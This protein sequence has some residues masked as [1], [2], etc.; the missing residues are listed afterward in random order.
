MKALKIFTVLFYILGIQLIFSQ[1]PSTISYQGILTDA[2]G[3]VVSDGSYTLTFG[4]YE[5]PTGGTPFWQEQHTV[6]VINGLFN[7]ILGSDAPLDPPFQSQYWLGIKIGSDPELM[8]RIQLTASP[9][10][11]N[12]RSVVGGT[13]VFPSEGNVGI[14][15]PEPQQKLHVAGISRFDVSSNAHVDISTPGGWP[16]LITIAPGGNRR[17]LIFDDGGIRLLTSPSSSA[18]PAQNGITIRENGAVGIGINV[19]D[20]QLSVAGTVE[21]T[22]GGFK[23]PDGSVQTSAAT[24]G[25][26]AN[27][28]KKNSADTSQ[29][30]DISPILL[31]SNLG[32]GDGFNG[33]SVD[34]RGVEGRSENNNGVQ[35]WTGSATKSAVFGNSI[36]GRGVEGRSETQ[37]GVDG[38]TGVSEASGV[39]GHS[40]DGFGVTGRSDNNR[41]IQ[42][43]GPT[44]IYGESSADYGE[45]IHG[46]GTGS[47]TEG[48]L[49]T[50]DNNVGV[51]G[52]S[53]GTTGNNFGVWGASDD[54]IGVLGAS[55]SGTALYAIGTFA[56]TG[57][58]SA[59]VKLKDGTPIRL[60]SEEATEVNF[61]DYGSDQLVNG[62]RHI[63]LDPVFLQTV[64]VNSANPMRV[65]VQLEGDC[66]GVYVTNKS[67][68]GFDVVELGGGNSSVPFSYRVVCKRKYFESQRLATP[69]ENNQQNKVM[70]QTVWPE[71]LEKQKERQERIFSKTGVR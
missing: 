19:P 32:S 16:G 52:I 26:A 43:F 7:I 21:S 40:T 30:T 42:G 45:A 10:S 67:N 70:M 44:A 18:A 48:V 64:T 66:N 37:D 5:A 24:G 39:F 20:E 61:C 60:F 11:L 13:N 2:G 63:E 25:G 55:T 34:G 56:A 31:V 12:A 41:G 69:E 38:W 46:H 33:R 51:Y 27:Y 8:P 59:E 62:R 68:T 50:S 49:G 4:L 29:A 54:G 17:D 36:N 6:D 3:T 58:K 47:F 14:G 22:T 1:V 28:I 15:V 57:T 9:Y 71:V 53:S 23:F 65:F 35:G